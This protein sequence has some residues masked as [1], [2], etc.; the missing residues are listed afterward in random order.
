MLGNSRIAE[1]WQARYS[2][3]LARRAVES[4]LA[5]KGQGVVICNRSLPFVEPLDSKMSPSYKHLVR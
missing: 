1:N 4:G 3:G 2:A 5:K